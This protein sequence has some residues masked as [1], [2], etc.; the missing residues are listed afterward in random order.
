MKPITL[1]NAAFA[2]WRREQHDR[3]GKR[4]AARENINMYLH[5]QLRQPVTKTDEFWVTP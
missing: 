3:F 5:M 2:G 4:G 1:K